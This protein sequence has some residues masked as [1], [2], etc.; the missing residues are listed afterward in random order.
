MKSVVDQDLEKTENQRDMAMHKKQLAQKA[1]IE[2]FKLIE[3]LD[4]RTGKKI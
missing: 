4:V 2:R 1:A 3:Q